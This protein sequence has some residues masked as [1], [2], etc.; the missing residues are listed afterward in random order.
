M[1][2]CECVNLVRMNR[3]KFVRA[4]CLLANRLVGQ[5]IDFRGLLPKVFSPRDFM[6]SSERPGIP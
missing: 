2:F 6:R 3:A 1:R 5:T 4:N